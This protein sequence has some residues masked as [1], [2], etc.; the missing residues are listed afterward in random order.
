MARPKSAD[1][2]IE[3]LIKRLPPADTEWP[4][5][6]QMAWINLMAMAFGTVYGGDA[7]TRLYSTDSPR[8][9]P[10]G[11]PASNVTAL[12]SRKPKPI[13]HKFYIDVEGYAR[14]NNGDRVLPNDVSDTLFDH[15]GID[16]DMKTITW[17]DDSQGIGGFGGT[18]AA[19]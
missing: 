12:P 7:A 3:A 1:P 5:E 16:G 4:V 17:A 2:L 11:P 9:A 8:P 18:V 6:K 13:P 14:R 10:A 15:R 19:A